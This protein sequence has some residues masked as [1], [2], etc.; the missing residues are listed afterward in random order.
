[1][2]SK[3]RFHFPKKTKTVKLYSFKYHDQNNTVREHICPD[4]RLTVIKTDE[5][6]EVSRRKPLNGK[7]D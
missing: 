2:V 5:Q 3:L 7:V 4:C 6:K 1:M